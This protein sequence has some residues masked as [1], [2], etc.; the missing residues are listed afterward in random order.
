M[1]FKYIFIS[2]LVLISGI[3]TTA[4][5]EMEGLPSVVA[6]EDS[7]REIISS[8]GENYDFLNDE[9]YMSK[10]NELVNLLVD[11][12]LIKEEHFEIGNLNDDNIP[13][14]VVFRERD[15][16]DVDDQG[17]LEIYGFLADKYGLLSRVPMNYDNTNY[18]LLIGKIG[19]G[20][21][22][23]LLNNQA[24]SQSG[25][26][27]GFILEEGNLVSVLN[28]SKINLV[29]INTDNEIKDIDKDGILEFSIVT[30]DPESNDES[31]KDVNKIKYWYK[32][33]GLD[34][35]ELVK[36]EKIRNNSPKKPQ[37]SS[38]D[39]LKEANTIIASD[40]QSF[41]EYLETNKASLSTI[42]TT[43]L[44]IEYFNTMIVESKAKEV[45]VNS[46]FSKYQL[47]NSNDYLLNKYELSLER[48]NDSAYLSRE[49]VLS[50]ETELKEHL[51]NNLK[52]GYKLSDKDGKYIYS[53]NYQ[54]FLDKFGENI[55]KEYRD[56]Y[57]I[58]ALNSNNPFV[59]NG[60]LMI[61]IEKLAERI[62]LIDNFKMTY[63]YS[64]FIDDLK[65]IYNDYLST[66]LF[67]S[68]NSPVFDK[69]SGLI[70]EEILSQYNSIR[71]KYPLLNLSDII[72]NYLNELRINGNRINSDIK[73]KF[74]NY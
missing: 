12:N 55:L 63:P 33:D 35:A 17:A 45:V 59:K 6:L 37:N 52:L 71:E 16:K 30:L 25:V 74:N 46:L 68:I 58:L 32:W 43:R 49:K 64:E 42:D 23:I 62:I 41:I 9:Q 20:Q 57:R 70:N 60:T 54:T 61:D 18:E 1:K 73:E 5:S 39:I 40:R 29:S 19:P 34:G 13:E 24:A 26:T 51:I 11:N 66:F 10:M 4:C 50:S 65:P 3:L 21:N 67:G 15:P 44:L 38:K 14:L 7:I 56:Y 72:T 69:E 28:G 31:T 22:G 47:D 48:L 36:H 53:I 27:Y 8:K 2:L